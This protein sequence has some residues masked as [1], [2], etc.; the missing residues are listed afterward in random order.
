[1]SEVN[2]V[3]KLSP[4]FFPLFKEIVQHFGKYTHL[5]SVDRALIFVSALIEQRGPHT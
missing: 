3:R 4:L 1:M 2:L 5:L